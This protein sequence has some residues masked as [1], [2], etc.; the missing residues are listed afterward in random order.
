MSALT[1][2]PRI[3]IGVPSALFAL[4]HYAPAEAGA[5][6][7]P[8]AIWAGLF[9]LAMADLT[10][11]SGTLG[12][13]IAVH[14]VNNALAILF[15]SFKGDLSGLAW[16]TL[17]SAMDDVAPVRAALPV[18]LLMLIVTWLAARVALRR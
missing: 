17:P 16:F 3:W 4:G 8:L 15:V 7:V 13:A 11:R 10:A 9:G 6:A 18:D 2:D 12:P 5:N 1:N 14:F